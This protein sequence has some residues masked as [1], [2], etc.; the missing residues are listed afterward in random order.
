MRLDQL[1]VVH[2]SMAELIGLAVRVTCFNERQGSP[3]L[4]K[5][6]VV[7]R[8]VDIHIVVRQNEIAFEGEFLDS[9]KFNRAA[10]KAGAVYLGN[11]SS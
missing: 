3:V 2:E 4:L 5:H 9:T 10:V 8:G 7:A 11:N 1:V 6:G